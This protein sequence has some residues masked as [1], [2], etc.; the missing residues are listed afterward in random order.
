VPSQLSVW[1]MPDPPPNAPFHSLVEPRHQRFA[2][3]ALRDL[4]LPMT[5]EIGPRRSLATSE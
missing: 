5:S 3:Y 1:E 4:G 2:L